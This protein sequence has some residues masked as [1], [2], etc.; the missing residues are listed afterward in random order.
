VL[1]LRL[2]GLW[3]WL[4]FAA[5]LVPLVPAAA[6]V[7]LLQLELHLLLQQHALLSVLHQLAMAW[8]ECCCCR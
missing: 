5:G 8:L 3:G 7:L 6:A 4:G 1:L 2:L